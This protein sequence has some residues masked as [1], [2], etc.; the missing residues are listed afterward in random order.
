[1]YFTNSLFCFLNSK[2]YCQVTLYVS[3]TRHSFDLVF[4][5]YLRLNLFRP[6]TPAFFGISPM[7]VMWIIVLDFS[8]G[9]RLCFLARFDC[10]VRIG[11]FRVGCW[12]V[13][14]FCTLFKNCHF[15]FGFKINKSILLIMLSHYSCRKSDLPER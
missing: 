8:F 12:L 10:Y 14:H 7:W 13:E 15:Y 4:N 2:F 3:I 6:F 11:S 1:M 9:L 5:F